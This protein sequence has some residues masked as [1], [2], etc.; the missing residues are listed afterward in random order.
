MGIM[1]TLVGGS[2]ATHLKS[3][4]DG[5]VKRA[6]ISLPTEFKQANEEFQLFSLLCEKV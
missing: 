2:S 4:A 5:R 3:L 1:N 6:P